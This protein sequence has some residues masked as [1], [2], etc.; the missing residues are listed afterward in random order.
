[1]KD[2]VQYYTELMIQLWLVLHTWFL[3]CVDLSVFA[4]LNII[5]V[6][7]NNNKI[8]ECFFK[9]AGQ[10]YIKK[11]FFLFKRRCIIHYTYVHAWF[12]SYK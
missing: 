2:S 12:P 11:K 10:I 7:K 1:M 3:Y 8:D 4:F 6:N 9:H 5:K